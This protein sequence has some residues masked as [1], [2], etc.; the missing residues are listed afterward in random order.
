MTSPAR[1]ALLVLA[2]P[3][4]LLGSSLQATAGAGTVVYSLPVGP[5]IAA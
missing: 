2:V 5:I 3:A 1:L 4:F